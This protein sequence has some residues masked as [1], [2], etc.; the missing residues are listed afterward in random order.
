MMC[1]I[2]LYTDFHDFHRVTF[3]TMHISSSYPAMRLST[4]PHL[5][6][7]LHYLTFLFATRAALA[8]CTCI[9]ILLLVLLRFALILFIAFRVCQWHVAILLHIQKF[10]KFYDI[11][12]EHY[13]QLNAYTRLL[14]NNIDFTNHINSCV[15]PFKVSSNVKS[16]IRS[17]YQHVGAHEKSAIVVFT[18]LLLLLF[19]HLKQFRHIVIR[20]RWCLHEM[21]SPLGGLRL[22]FCAW[23]FAQFRRLINFIANCVWERDDAWQ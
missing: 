16:H 3:L 6:D 9:A 19:T 17:E 11:T 13:F 20:L 4:P 23:Y 5:V 21:Y 15:A 7:F 1:R 18:F 2:C 12:P 22:S 10:L 14:E 8:R